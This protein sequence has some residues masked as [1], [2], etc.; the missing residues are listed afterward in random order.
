MA[1]RPLWRSSPDWYAVVASSVS[2]SPSSVKRFRSSS[3]K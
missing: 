1:S 3:R 2:S